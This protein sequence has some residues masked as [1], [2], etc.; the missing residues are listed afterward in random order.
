VA[1]VR[2]RSPIFTVCR[3]TRRTSRPSCKGMS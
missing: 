3:E 2:L 1:R